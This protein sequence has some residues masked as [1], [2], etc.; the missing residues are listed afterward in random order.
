MKALSI[1][2]EYAMEMLNGNKTEEYRTW[3]TS[4]RGD[5]LICNT[6]KKTRGAVAGYALCVAKIVDIE[7]RYDGDRI[8]YAWKIAPFE[9]GGSYWIEPLKVKGQRRL[10]N[11]DDVLIKPAPFSN[12]FS[13]VGEAWYQ[14]KIIPL[15]H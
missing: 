1:H 7:K 13:A 9:T 15:I 4:Y 12:P 6:A 10:F 2:P 5:L 14:E 11:V 3:T 8:C